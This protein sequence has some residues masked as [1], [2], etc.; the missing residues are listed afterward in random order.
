MLSKFIIF[1]TSIFLARAVFAADAKYV[2]ICTTQVDNP[3]IKQVRIKFSPYAFDRDVRKTFNKHVH[4]E[5]GLFGDDPDGEL[6]TKRYS[7]KSIPDYNFYVRGVEKDSTSLT[8]KVNALRADA[9]IKI[10]LDQA[11]LPKDQVA[12]RWESFDSNNS[13]DAT[14]DIVTSD[15]TSQ[16]G[17]KATCRSAEG[18]ASGRKIMGIRGRSSPLGSGPNWAF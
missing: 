7:V 4:F 13:Y 12:D 8:Y 15:Q 2:V 10:H 1:L 14:I 6:L 5:S 18:S 16:R 9:T 11:Q 3:A 17:L